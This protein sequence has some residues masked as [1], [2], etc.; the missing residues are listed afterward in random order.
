MHNLHEMR[1]NTRLINVPRHDEMYSRQ[2]WTKFRR[3]VTYRVTAGG[4]DPPPPSR[5]RLLATTTR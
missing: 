2:S 1:V 4:F 5:E 3:P